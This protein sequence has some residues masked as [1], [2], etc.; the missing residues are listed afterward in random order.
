MRA[1]A[2]WLVVLIL[3]APPAVAGTGGGEEINSAAAN[4]SN[5][6]AKE[7]AA[8][9]TAAPATPATPAQP[10]PA[11]L[12][13][14]LQQLRD[15]IEAQSKQLQ[16]QNEQLKDQQRKMQEME[17]ELKNVN[18]ST[19]NSGLAFA[20]DPTAIG[21]VGYGADQDKKDE[22]SIAIHFKGVTFT[23]G[24][25]FAAE[26][27]YRSRALSDDVNTDFKAIPMPG[28]SMA[29]MSENNFSGR[30]SR[31]SGKFEGRADTVRLTGYYEADFLGAG[32]TSTNTI[33][34]SYVFRQRQIWGQAA[35][36]NG[37]TV[38]GGQM[39]SLATEN[40]KGLDNLTEI[41]PLTID[42]QYTAGFTWARQY[43]LRVTKNFGDKFWLGASV[44]G[45]Q[46]TFTAHGFAIMQ[47]TTTPSGATGDAVL[48]TTAVSSG[49]TLVGAAGDTTGLFNN[50][51]NYSFNPAPDFVAKA[52]W[53]P[54][55]GHYEV[56][57]IVDEFRTRIFPCAFI[58]AS[59]GEC[60]I[61]ATITTP[62]PAHASNDNRTG[63]GVGANARAP[64]FNN[65][66]EF[67][68]HLFV[69]S[70]VGRYGT[71][72]LPDAT[73][74]GDGTFALLR[75]AQGL[76]SL[77]LKPIP[78]L[79]IYG[80]AGME[81]VGRGIYTGPTGTAGATG[82]GL[83]SA[84]NAGCGIET[85][86]NG[87]NTALTSVNL[88]DGTAGATKTGLSPTAYNGYQPGSPGSC[89]AD[90]RVIIEGTL[91]FWYRF[92]QGGPKGR[93]QAGAQYSYVTRNAWGAT[94]GGSPHGTENMVFTSL[95][96]Y[97][98]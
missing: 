77:I 56:F 24:G 67:G 15:L 66:L 48:L 20:S 81:Y 29:K 35:W 49:N 36:D 62:S 6:A 96:Y 64:F 34:N 70:G 37:W 57:G 73:L 98:P 32:V 60:P 85:L 41:T 9:N 61:D 7:N 38:T 71:T 63:G 53:E 14:Q 78:R 3:V 92:I 12:D 46:A 4:S 17:E 33:S 89:T 25:F 94:A 8:G 31:I 75:S 30:Q 11:G 93:M 87:A 65:H 82:Y 23:P 76:G 19:A 27:V 45:S 5:T 42:A 80:Y 39:F 95:R 84:S 83:F 69:G 44:E 90:S 74:R 59:T 52:A 88:S 18:A 28:S 72:T 21:S 10:A 40:R 43:G 26:T 55:W 54:G 91:G 2:A 1:L 13:N 58:P 68:L 51:A 50:Q 79:D 97:L 22:S 16:V 47:T 86:P